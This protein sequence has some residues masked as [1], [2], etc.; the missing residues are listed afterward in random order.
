M[1]LGMGRRRQRR[2][3]GRRCLAVFLAML[4]MVL[5][6]PLTI[7]VTA[8]GQQ[9]QP[10]PAASA[11]QTTPGFQ[12]FLAAIDYGGPSHVSGVFAYGSFAYPV[13]Q[14]P[15]T[16]PAF[17]SSQANVVTQFRLASN[18][19]T[20]AFLAHNTLSG[21]A[22]QDLHLGQIVVVVYS[23]GTSRKYQISRIRRYQALDPNSPYSNFLS[24]DGD[25]TL[26]SSSQLFSQVYTQ[27]DQVVFQTC[28]ALDGEDSWGRLF[29]TAVPLVQP[30]HYEDLMAR[31]L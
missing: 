8:D 17:V 19:G 23:D 24:L 4:W 12:E 29:V 5:S 31:I 27:G 6:F 26:L 15:A 10:A 18:F 20:T 11:D 28:I 30:L 25:Q 3:Q 7:P 9:A 1:R 13:V 2:R 14:Q 21:K 22:F 16:N